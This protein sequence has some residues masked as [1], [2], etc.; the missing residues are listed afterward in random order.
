MRCC[1]WRKGEK[2]SAQVHPT[3]PHIG[4]TISADVCHSS[5]NHAHVDVWPD[6][7]AAAQEEDSHA[8]KAAAARLEHEDPAERRAA[9]EALGR[10]GAA[11]E[12][13]APQLARSAVFDNFFGVRVVALELLGRLRPCVV[14]PHFGEL[15]LCL[16]D[17]DWPVRSAAAL[18]LGELNAVSAP[19][20]GQAATATA[21]ATLLEDP[22][23]DVRSASQRALAMLG[24][25]AVPHVLPILDVALA[26]ARQAAA[27]LLGRLCATTAEMADCSAQR[28]AIRLRDDASSV[29][30]AAA[31]SLGQMGPHGAAAAAGFL[32]DVEED[33][34]LRAVEVLGT[35]GTAALPH[36]AEIAKLLDDDDADVRQTAAATL[37][38]LGWTDPR[39]VTMDEEDVEVVPLTVWELA[40]RLGS[41]DTTAQRAALRAFWELGHGKALPHLADFARCLKDDDAKVRVAAV[42][43]LGRAGTACGGVHAAALAGRLAA[44][45]EA[46]VRSAAAEAL[47]NMGCEVAAPHAD[48]LADRLSDLDWHVREAVV[49]ALG[50][51]AGQVA[52]PHVVGLVR[53]LEADPYPQVRCAAAVSLR[54]LGSEVAAQAVDNLASSACKD[55]NEEV[56]A[57]AADA[58]Q[59]VLN[60]SA[61][62]DD[63]QTAAAAEDWD[64]AEQIRDDLLPM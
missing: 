9:V 53:R 38:D 24:G 32:C 46:D 54:E 47:G 30:G 6:C 55:A 14:A 41:G 21:L 63:D 8:A 29:R 31:A 49:I 48:T 60:L 51:L 36:V 20:T 43:L 45:K 15:V 56:R 39:F 26:D 62:C 52:L 5:K 28:L 42:Q 33:V 17:G 19:E 58:L 40:G 44:D 35:L 37:A 64:E 4:P 57:A 18:A 61:D 50:R 13:Y 23:E 34:R 7:A 2:A 12:P 27:E 3:S 59:I 16:G 1:L 10:L 22:H 25:A 11:T